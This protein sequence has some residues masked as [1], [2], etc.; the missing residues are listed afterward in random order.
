MIKYLILSLKYK[1]T[2][3]AWLVTIKAPKGIS[4]YY[5]SYS[6]EAKLEV[7]HGFGDEQTQEDLMSNIRSRS[8]P[9]WH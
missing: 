3:G 4:I 8:R 5:Q 9:G 6:L 1:S 2:V 7:G